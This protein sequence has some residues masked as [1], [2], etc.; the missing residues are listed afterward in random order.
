[1]HLFQFSDIYIYIYVYVIHIYMYMKYYIY[2]FYICLCLG[3]IVEVQACLFWARVSG[4]FPR[5][6]FHEHVAREPCAH[7]KVASTNPRLA[8]CSPLASILAYLPFRDATG[9]PI[10]AHTHTHTHTPDT[11]ARVKSLEDVSFVGCT[12]CLSIRCVDGVRV[13]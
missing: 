7:V 2:I 6:L 4:L 13:T 5:Q 11:R 12:L 10:R 9:E 8:L 1:M 3:V